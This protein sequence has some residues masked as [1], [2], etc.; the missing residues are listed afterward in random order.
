MHHSH[1]SNQKSARRL[2]LSGNP[3]YRKFIALKTTDL[4]S[5]KNKEGSSS[6]LMQKF[7]SRRKFNLKLPSKRLPTSPSNVFGEYS[8]RDFNN[9]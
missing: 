6:L 1:S 7:N 3:I 2:K 9:S 8:D 4:P 5:P